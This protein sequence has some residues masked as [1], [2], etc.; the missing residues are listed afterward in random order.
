MDPEVVYR[1]VRLLESNPT[2]DK[3]RLH[4]GDYEP[5]V[6]YGTPNP[7]TSSVTGIHYSH[8]PRQHL[9]GGNYGKGMRG[10]EARRLANHPDKRIS[11]RVHFY[12]DEG[13]G[14]RPE[15]GVG[16]VTHGVKLHN[17]YDARANPKKY[18]QSDWS[19]FE[20]KLVDD[21]YHGVY[22]S[23]AQGDQG[24]AVLLGDHNEKVPVEQVNKTH[25]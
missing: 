13:S 10:A 25:K 5:S 18:D 20:S 19:G 9:S 3:G 22:V 2:W 16:H 15:T 7:H 21:G 23:K 24:V 4:I 14:I 1:L 8:L 6:S 12:V 17:L 11:K